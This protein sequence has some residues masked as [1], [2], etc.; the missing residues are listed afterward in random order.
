MGPPTHHITVVHANPS[1]RLEDQLAGMASAD[2][3][4]VQVV[5]SALTSRIAEDRGCRREEEDVTKS[6]SDSGIDD[7]LEVKEYRSS[8][9]GIAK[10]SPHSLEA[11]VI[12]LKTAGG[13]RRI[14]DDRRLVANGRRKVGEAEEA[15]H[16]YSN[17]NENGS[18]NLR[19]SVNLRRDSN[20]ETGGSN[21]SDRVTDSCIIV[22]KDVSECININTRNAD[23]DKETNSNALL[24]QGAS[25]S[26]CKE[27][28]AN[29]SFSWDGE[30]FSSSL[31]GDSEASTSFSV[32]K[33]DRSGV[34][35]YLEAS[36]NFLRDGEASN[37]L[38]L[39]E[40]QD[41][42]AA[43]DTYSV[44]IYIT[45][46]VAHSKDA[47]DKDKDVAAVVAVNRNDPV[48]YDKD[49]LICKGAVT[50]SVARFLL[51]GDRPNNGNN[52]LI[53]RNMVLT[54]NREVKDEKEE[55]EE[56]DEKEV[57]EVQEVKESMKEEEEDEKE[58]KE[59]VDDK[60]NKE[61]K[62]D[63]MRMEF[64]KEMEEPGVEDEKEDK[65]EVD[66]IQIKE[67]ELEEKMEWEKE[68]EQDEKKEQD[69]E[70]EKED[71]GTED[72]E[73]ED[74]GF[75]RFNFDDYPESVFAEPPMGEASEEEEKE[76]RRSRRKSSQCI[77][78]HPED[79]YQP[80]SFSS[81]LSLHVY[82]NIKS[83]S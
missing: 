19:D 74:E 73:T 53:V 63:K 26:D 24:D 17:L 18:Y 7:S 67:M 54:K 49:S 10:N 31:S 39:N 9:L 36:S 28:E 1:H 75:V 52:E 41:G 43:N 2:H 46:P 56:K 13:H 16:A 47:C 29:S 37:S 48:I 60:Q 4:P 77:L 79:V 78:L 23:G 62:E 11:K 50:D 38:F 76:E 59:E 22:D 57:N 44:R 8:D 3:E 68:M 65:E 12:R 80:H 71:D 25:S 45:D 27:G 20:K 33:D 58:E 14:Q 30:A 35:T 15:K 81:L 72:E 61:E 32:S 70:E 64:E 55:K 5:Y 6:D 66:E 69:E 40:N 83:V 51:A 42:T 82:K 21:N 34:S